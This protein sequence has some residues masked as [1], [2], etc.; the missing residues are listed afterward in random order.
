MTDSG[1]ENSKPGR[2]HLP[3]TS[4]DPLN[5]QVLYYNYRD[6]YA[7]ADELGFDGIMTNEHGSA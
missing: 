7:W 4:F 2:M 1:L 5:A 3:N 6:Q